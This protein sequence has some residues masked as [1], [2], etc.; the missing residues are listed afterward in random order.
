MGLQL[1]VIKSLSANAEKNLREVDAS[2]TF[3]LFT[4]TINKLPKIVFH[5]A[6]VIFENEGLNGG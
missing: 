5:T 4:R 3:A 2:F 1:S 6:L